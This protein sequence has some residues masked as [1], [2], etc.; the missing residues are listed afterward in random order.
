MNISFRFT[1]LFTMLCAVAPA[2]SAA[3]QQNS[4]W[5]SISPATL[6]SQSVRLPLKGGQSPSV[7]QVQLL[8]DR[9][10]FSPGILDGRWGRNTDKAVRRFQKREGLNGT[11][12]VDENTLE[13]LR[14]AAGN[15]QQL[16]TRHTLSEEEVQGPFVTI[17]EDIYAKAEMECMCYE[18]LAEKLGEMFHTSP[19]LLRQ[20]NPGINL[21]GLKA[22]DR[23]MVLNVRDRSAK[24]DGEVN[25][26]VIA[27]GGHYLHAL[28][29]QGRILFHAP[30]TLGSDFAPSP[31]GHFTVTRIAHDPTW[32][33]QPDL[34]TG[35]P[36]EKRDAVIPPGPNNAVG[37][38]WMDLSKPHYG[39]HGT[40]APETIGYAT[41]H[42]CVRLTNWDA[43][44]LADH[45]E[46]G[47][48][49]EFTT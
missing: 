7:L 6:N 47:M 31:D 13:R 30:S 3:A 24:L 34:L 35:V 12:T 45:V 22:G 48:P 9:A 21:N 38:V 2:G 8:L 15:P 41:S 39:I 25:R 26:V 17:P 19:A 18:S 27:D 49:V 14:Q 11:G 10:M 33:Y 23:L 20:L 44:F 4:R 16:A 5:Q 36:D 37:V 29:A 32:H 28:D 40:S 1:A 43:L 46:Q 42:G